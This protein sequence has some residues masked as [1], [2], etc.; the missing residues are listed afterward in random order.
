M[1][2]TIYCLLIAI[3]LRVAWT[4]TVYTMYDPPPPKPGHGSAAA[5]ISDGDRVL[6]VK[7]RLAGDMKN[8]LVIEAHN[9]HEWKE[10]GFDPTYTRVVCDYKPMF[11]KL[12]NGS[13]EIMFTSELAEGIP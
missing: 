5:F 7:G 12:P 3:C 10:N 13:W 8:W 11:R 6:L 9:G 1:K 4:Q 2:T